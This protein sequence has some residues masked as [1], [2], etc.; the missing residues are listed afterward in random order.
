MKR[1][2]PLSALCP[3][4]AARALLAR[5]ADQVAHTLQGFAADKKLAI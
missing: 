2:E 4:L 1:R 3:P 5:A